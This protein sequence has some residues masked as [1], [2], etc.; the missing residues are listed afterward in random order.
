[1]ILFSTGVAINARAKDVAEVIIFK[2]L[3]FSSARSNDTQA[4]LAMLVWKNIENHSINSERKFSQWFNF[5]LR[6]SARLTNNEHNLLAEREGE[7][8]S[9][10]AETKPSSETW[11]FN[12]RSQA[13]DLFLKSQLW[14]IFGK[15]K[16][17]KFRNLIKF[18]CAPESY[19]CELF[20]I[21]ILGPPKSLLP[22]TSGTRFLSRA[23]PKIAAW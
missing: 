20:P 11:S 23:I 4:L 22:Q 14:A 13:E 2:K 17:G 7:W 6:F 19:C 9:G 5:F 21:N 15:Q 3:F 16:D 8:K 12:E 1:M 18:A 10:E